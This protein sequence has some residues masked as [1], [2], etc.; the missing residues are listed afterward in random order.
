MMNQKGITT[1]VVLIG[2]VIA[3]IVLGSGYY[4]GNLA[5]PLINKSSQTSPTP[6]S[7][8]SESPKPTISNVK[9]PAPST[10]NQTSTP[11]P[12]PQSG[13]PADVPLFA[14]A[15]IAYTTRMKS[16]GYQESNKFCEVNSFIYQIPKPGLSVDEVLNWYVSN[17]NPS[18]VYGTPTFTQANS[19]KIV[20]GDTYFIIRIAGLNGTDNGVQLTF[21]GRYEQK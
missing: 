4:L 9:S 1:V 13:L 7:T 21:E 16:C 11:Q 19:G 6:T 20:K 8:P 10:S 5:K 15:K 2:V 17:P 12:I 3:L 14:G 18:W